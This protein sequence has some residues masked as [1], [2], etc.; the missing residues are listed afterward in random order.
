MEKYN[1]VRNRL[2]DIQRGKKEADLFPVLKQLFIEKKYTDVE[3]IHGK[4]E[5]GKD[6]VLCDY[7]TK[8]G[9]KNWYAVVVKKSRRNH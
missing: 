6:L 8:L 9:E 3:V 1:N 7:D 5:Y 4:D 2:M